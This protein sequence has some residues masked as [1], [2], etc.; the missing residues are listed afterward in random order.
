[1]SFPQKQLITI[2]MRDTHIHL[3]DFDLQGH[4]VLLLHFENHFSF[5]IANLLHQIY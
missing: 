3:I 1:M 4:F 2:K 5:I